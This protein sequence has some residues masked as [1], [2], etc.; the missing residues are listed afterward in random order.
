M[1]SRTQRVGSL[2]SVVALMGAMALAPQGLAQAAPQPIPADVVRAAT[3]NPNQIDSI[4]AWTTYWTARLIECQ[5][6]DDVQRARE[7]LMRPFQGGINPQISNVFRLHYSQHALPVLEGAIHNKDGKSIHCATNA[8]NV[9]SMLGTDSALRTLWTHCDVHSQPSSQIRLRAAVG[10]AT[11]L[12]GDTIDSRKIVDAA[13]KL[14]D[15][16]KDEVDNLVLLRQFEAINAADH[17]RL[18]HD[19]RQAVR[20]A[21]VDAICVAVDAKV[22]DER[23]NKAPIE[24][25]NS[26][27]VLVREKF[28]RGD[29][30]AD[31]AKQLGQRLGPRLGRVLE[32]ISTNWQPAQS[33]ATK[34]MYG[35]VVGTADGFLPRI[36]QIVRGPGKS[37]K[38][39]LRDAWTAANKEK[40]DADVKLW[41]DAL[42]QAPYEKP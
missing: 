4:K 27:V 10:C 12:R 3:L 11:L 19:D 6:P 36:D 30:Q 17:N 5:D 40:F 25:I 42:R 14:R 37:P 23:Q 28:I 8:I 35:V 26:A 34:K 38:T 13:K 22:R 24:A 33:D 15:A 7:E 21:L 2:T 9:I 39:T 32:F 16:S 1:D 41:L 18:Q 20:A 31:E 29:L